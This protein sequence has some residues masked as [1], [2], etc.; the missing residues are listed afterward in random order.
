MRVVVKY[1]DNIIA[2]AFN[3]QVIELE[4][5]GHKFTDNLYVESHGKAQI[6][7]PIS[8]TTEEDMAQL[9][10]NTT[11]YDSGKIF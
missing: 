10:A 6:V 11:P 4:C 7:E 3:G 2:T 9:L 5:A 8:M 1:K